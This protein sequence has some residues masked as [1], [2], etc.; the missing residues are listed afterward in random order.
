MSPLDRHNILAHRRT[1]SSKA[2]T[3]PEKLTP[4]LP[5]PVPEKCYLT[6]MTKTLVLH[7]GM[8]KTAT[9]T[10]QGHFFSQAKGFLGK[11]MFPLKS[12]LTDDF[13]GVHYLFSIG[14]EW[15]DA[16]ESW[17]QKLDFSESE[18]LIVSEEGLSSWPSPRAPGSS[19]YPVQSPGVHEVGRSGAHPI[20]IFLSR[21][22]D[23]LPDDVDLLT[24][25]SLRNQSDFLGSFA[26][27]S[28]SVAPGAVLSGVERNDP[29]LDYYTI[30]TDLERTVGSSHHLTLL[31]ED[32]VEHNCRKIAEFA[33]LTATKGDFNFSFDRVENVRRLA[34]S[35][36]K[37]NYVPRY[38]SGVILFKHQLMR[39]L[40]R[41]AE[42]SR[43]LVR[44]VFLH[45]AAPI[46]RIFHFRSPQSITVSQDTRA[47]IRDHCEL[48]N[49]RLAE[50]L[51]RDLVALGY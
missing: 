48:S 22:M 19:R 43:I 44:I 5:K 15:S 11:K 13:A 45:I 8:P 32:G 16:L 39:R 46:Y 24:I 18:T 31:F 40:P 4:K 26:A 50:H 1:L 7:L 27:Q 2:P 9:T 47:V 41:V 10:I 37:V 28:Q 17:L 38:S 49:R 23:L 14:K 34:D 25:I 36:W 33:S 29:F 51:N 3:V 21:V 12:E 20:T 30:V 6:V 42:L 35:S